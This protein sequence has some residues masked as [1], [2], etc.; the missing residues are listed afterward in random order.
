M[1]PLSSKQRGSF[2]L[3]ALLLVAGIALVALAQFRAAIIPSRALGFRENERQRRQWYDHLAAEVLDQP[4]EGRR[5]AFSIEEEDVSFTQ[6]RDADGALETR[7][8]ALQATDHEAWPRLSLLRLT[9]PQFDFYL[10]HF[11]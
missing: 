10:L 9:S 6:W 2:S 8:I 5:G 3:V 11:D 1:R 4:P 7:I